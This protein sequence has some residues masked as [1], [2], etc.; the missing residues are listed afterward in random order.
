[1]ER[2]RPCRYYRL[3][4]DRAGVFEV[5]RIGWRPTPRPRWIGWAVTPTNRDGGCRPNVGIVT[6]LAAK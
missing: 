1:L 4:D 6:H 2:T 5:G 3:V